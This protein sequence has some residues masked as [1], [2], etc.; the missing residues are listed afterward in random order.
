[1]TFAGSLPV[2]LL[3]LAAQAHAGEARFSEQRFL[4]QA[5]TDI[6]AD[7]EMGRMAEARATDPVIKQYAADA[8]AHRQQ[9]TGELH[10]LPGAAGIESPALDKEGRGAA[11]ALAARKG[12]DFDRRYLLTEMKNLDRDLRVFRRAARDA[13]DPEVKAFAARQAS[14]IDEQILKVRKVVDTGHLANKPP[15]VPTLEERKEGTKQ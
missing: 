2:F 3:A 5:A 13:K 6:A 11:K 1:M 4:R 8:V 15:A 12:M 14:L 9:L 10:K 7:V